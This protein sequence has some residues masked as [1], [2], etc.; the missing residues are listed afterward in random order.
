M[1]KVERGTLCATIAERGGWSPNCRPGCPGYSLPL[2]AEYC[3]FS[4]DD[5]FDRETL[6]HKGVSIGEAGSGGL[7][8]LDLDQANLNVQ[9]LG[10]GHRSWILLGPCKSLTGLF[11]C[12]GNDAMVV[13]AGSPDESIGLSADLINDWATMYVGTG[14]VCYGAR[15]TIESRNSIVIGDGCLISDQ[16]EL[17]SSDSHAIIALESGAVIN[18]PASILLEPRVWLSQGVVVLKNVTIG[19]GSI[20]ATRSVVTK[21]VPPFCLATGVPARVTRTAVSWHRSYPS[22]IAGSYWEMGSSGFVPVADAP[23]AP[24]QVA[25]LQRRPDATSEAGPGLDSQDRVDTKNEEKVTSRS[26]VELC[27]RI[28][29][30]REPESTTIVDELAK[31]Y[32]TISA[33]RLAMLHS[34]EFKTLYEAIN[35]VG[36]RPL[37]S[38]RNDV[39]VVVTPDY[40][41]QMMAR[42]ESSW[43]ELGKSEPFWSVLV[44]DRFLL[45]N[46]KGDTAEFYESGRAD[47]ELF[48]SAAARAGITEFDD[49]PVCMEYGCG[50]GRLS[51]WL[52]ERFRRVMACDISQPHLDNA[53]LALNARR[54]DNIELIRVAAVDEV[55]NLSGY[56]VFFSVIVLQHNPPPI[57]AYMIEQSLRNLN[58]GVWPIS[59]FPHTGWAISLLRSNMWKTKVCMGWRCT[60]SR[61]SSCSSSLPAAAA[62][63]WRSGKMIGSV[64]RASS[65]IAFFCK[66][67]SWCVTDQAETTSHDRR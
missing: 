43:E 6:R 58:A 52:A 42:V 44:Q 22:L 24:L 26:E 9:I 67:R 49:L 34:D 40:L 54:I 4:L 15:G 17:R 32:E 62:P 64:T 23:R 45:A 30:G 36:L 3:E 28:L 29:L 10:G 31:T 19:Q 56:D 14:G 27:Y 57:A 25:P 65:R 35:A 59:K 1:K 7:L 2:P 41:K 16:I 5:D 18:I 11:Q 60:S 33:L 53:R 50:I 47:V 55:A 61:R 38:P 13:F 37:S 66:S 63:C 39:E 20:V 21:N 8:Y 12:I 48:F 51:V 46:L